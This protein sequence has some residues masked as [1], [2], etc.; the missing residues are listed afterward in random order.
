[1]PPLATR[2]H[3]WLFGRLEPLVEMLL[4]SVGKSNVGRRRPLHPKLALC[5]L[6]PTSIDR[7]PVIWSAGAFPQG[8]RGDGAGGGGQLEGV[9]RTEVAAVRL[10]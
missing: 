7:R 2:C 6:Y 8:E 10:R 3:V 9:A 1:M 4:E 5:P